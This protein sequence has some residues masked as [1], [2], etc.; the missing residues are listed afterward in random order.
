MFMAAIASPTI[1]SGHTDCHRKAVT[2][3]AKT[4]ATFGNRIVS[5]GQEGRPGEAAAV[6]SEASKNEGTCE[7]YCQGAGT[8]H[9][10]G[11][12]LRRN[13]MGEFTPQRPQQRQRRY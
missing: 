8:G 12:R 5:G 4:I 9:R 11:E 6:S 10:Q 1:T 7:V 3:P 2:R 13:G